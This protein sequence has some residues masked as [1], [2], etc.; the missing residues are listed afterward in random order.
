MYVNAFAKLDYICARGHNCSTRWN[1]FQQHYGCIHCAIEDNNGPG[2]PNWKGGIS[3]E[4]YCQEWTKELKEF[5]KQRDGYKCMN[6]C[7][8]SKHPDKLAVHHIKYNKKL[9]GPKDLI[10]TCTSCNP[11]ANYDREFYEAWY[12]AIM[13][14][15][16]GY[17]Y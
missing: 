11:A 5:V 14:R 9:C 1:D 16:Y 12:K 8:K 10:T 2:N 4:P 13:Y 17:N 3:K 15:R 7:C 6:P